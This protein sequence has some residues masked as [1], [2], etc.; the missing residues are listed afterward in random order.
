MEQLMSFL[1]QY[2][3]FSV[4]GGLTIGTIVTFAITQIKFLRR[5]KEKSGVVSRLMYKIE[6]IVEKNNALATQ[7]QE[8]AEMHEAAIKR[9]QTQDKAMALTFKAISYLVVSSKLPNEDK[10][11]LQEDFIGLAEEI[12]TQGVEAGTKIVHKVAE[13]IP[14]AKEEVAT[15]ITNTLSTATTLLDKYLGGK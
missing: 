5:D 7:N 12:K 8:L 13:T 4:V 15:I 9:T 6:E 2:W 1:E 10:L 11:A 3:G 14:E